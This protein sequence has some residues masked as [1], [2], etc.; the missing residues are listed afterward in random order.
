M[1]ITSL[2]KKLESVN[3]PYSFLVTFPDSTSVRKIKQ[4]SCDF[5]IHFRHSNAFRKILLRG[6]LGFFESYID[7]DLDIKGDIPKL[8]DFASDLIGKHSTEPPSLRDRLFDWLH[9]VRFGNHTIKQAVANAKFHY[10]QGSKDLFFKYLDS[11]S[12][13]NIAPTYTCAY[14]KE[15]TRDLNEAQFNKLDHICRK[16]QLQS[17]DHLVD[18]GG[19]WGSLLFHALERYNISYGLNISPTPDQN[20]WMQKQID[21]LNLQE[22]LAIREA[23]FRQIAGLEGL[24]DKY[25]ST[26][27]YEHAGRPQLA[28][29]IKAMAT[30]LKPGGKGVLHFIGKQDESLTYSFIRK[31]VFPGGYLPGLGETVDLMK[32]NGLEMLDVEN[33]RR[34]YA[35]TLTEWAKN[36]DNNWEKIHATDPDVFT[37][38]FGRIWHLYLWLCVGAFQRESAGIGLYQITFS[39]GWTTDYPMSRGFLYDNAPSPTPTTFSR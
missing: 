12:P 10:N 39:K 4:N 7:G 3:S 25:I 5:E 23:D 36:F 34:H 8:I 17:G 29:W 35:L 33:L 37:E 9:E 28:A 6:D 13:F 14:W 21:R 1:L 11:T 31:Y 38:R 27:V 32:Q 20:E 19:G 24:F 15:G 22:R 26:G 18:V 30:L 2:R 16:V